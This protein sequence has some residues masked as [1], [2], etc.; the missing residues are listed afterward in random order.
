MKLKENSAF[1]LVAVI[2]GMVM[3]MV[4]TPVF[5]YAYS[6]SMKMVSQSETA[7]ENDTTIE[8][9]YN[10]YRNK[11]YDDTVS[12]TDVRYN[13]KYKYDA[14]VE[15]KI[16]STEESYKKLVTITVKNNFGQI[17]NKF[18]INKIRLKAYQQETLTS[19]L[20][21]DNYMWL[22]LSTDDKQ[23][24]D[25][26][27]Y[28]AA[29]GGWNERYSLNANLDTHNKY[30]YVHVRVENMEG[31]CDTDYGMMGF[32]EVPESSAYRFVYSSYGRR[33]DATHPEQWK[34]SNVSFSSAGYDATYPVQYHSSTW[35]WGLWSSGECHRD[36][37]FSAKLERVKDDANEL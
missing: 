23:D 17:V 8:D 25:F 14:S 9:L 29:D 32:I 31:P 35:G 10:L 19:S 16:D 21:G 27:L 13:D 36:A 24:G 11:P 22:Y 5:L 15:E 33:A 2:I 30:Y 28:K 37:Y 4:I 12:V 6:A 7:D 1:S 18:T 20:L 34:A 26:Y 3:L